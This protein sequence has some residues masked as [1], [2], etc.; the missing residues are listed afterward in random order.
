[1]SC[2]GMTVTKLA[3]TAPTSRFASAMP[4]FRSPAMSLRMT[5]RL[6]VAMIS[7]VKNR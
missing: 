2:A 5:R 3:R 4:A 6:H 1:M 7:A